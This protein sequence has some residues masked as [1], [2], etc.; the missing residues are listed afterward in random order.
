V[1][2]FLLFTFLRKTKWN[3]KE[4]N[5]LVEQPFSDSYPPSTNQFVPSYTLPSSPSLLSLPLLITFVLFLF[6]LPH[7]PF[8]H[9]TKLQFILF[10]HFFKENQSLKHFRLRC[11][12]TL[13]TKALK[14]LCSIPYPLSGSIAYAQPTLNHSFF[15]R[16]VFILRHHFTDSVLFMKPFILLFITHYKVH[17]HPPPHIRAGFPLFPALAFSPSALHLKSLFWK[18]GEESKKQTRPFP[19]F[20]V[21]LWG[22]E[23][24]PT[25][26]TKNDER[27]FFS[28]RSTQILLF[29]RLPVPYR[30]FMRKTRQSCL[31]LEL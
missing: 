3:G 17:P 21:V 15:S 20:V 30:F 27:K 25:K 13:Q 18:G 16:F 28:P 11:R 23:Q 1:C 22:R 24:Q 26:K 7:P 29:M 14:L 6:P 8:L 2:F 9:N 31:F 10:V 4:E 5:I 12:C 19:P